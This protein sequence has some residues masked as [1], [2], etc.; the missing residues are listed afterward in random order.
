MRLSFL[1]LWSLKDWKNEDMII[2][3]NSIRSKNEQFSCDNSLWLLSTCQFLIWV[4]KVWKVENMPGWYDSGVHVLK[5][6][7][8][9]LCI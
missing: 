3:D 5:I 8:C 4:C 2:S 1:E 7:E 6:L 9:I